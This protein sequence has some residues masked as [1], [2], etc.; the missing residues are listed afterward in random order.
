MKQNQ[1]EYAATIVLGVALGFGICLLFYVFLM[2][3]LQGSSTQG[4]GLHS[5]RLALGPGKV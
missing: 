4:A 3:A 1:L 5:L 2:W